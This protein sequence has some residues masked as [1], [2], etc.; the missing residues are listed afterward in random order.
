MV[1]FMSSG[2]ELCVSCC[3][4]PG[5]QDELEEYGRHLFH[6]FFMVSMTR[7]EVGGTSRHHSRGMSGSLAASWISHL[8][9]WSNAWVVFGVKFA[10]DSRRQRIFHS[11]T[12]EAS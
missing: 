3:K 4:R 5:G 9:S 6:L 7:S 1:A 12:S 11:N 2:R 10:S 8:R